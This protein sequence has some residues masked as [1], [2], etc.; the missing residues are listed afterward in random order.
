MLTVTVV[1]S[2]QTGTRQAV[3]AA[4]ATTPRPTRAGANRLRNPPSHAPAATASPAEGK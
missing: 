2:R 4:A 1:S 3:R